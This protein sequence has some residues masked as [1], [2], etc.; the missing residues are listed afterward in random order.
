MA[1]EEVA[2]AAVEAAAVDLEAVASAEEGIIVALAALCF[3][4]AHAFTEATVT[5]AVVWE[6]CWEC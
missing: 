6:A 4:E 2:L 5:E 3:S 1:S